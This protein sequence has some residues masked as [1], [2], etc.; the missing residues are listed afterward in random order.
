V[1]EDQSEKWA[2]ALH[3]SIGS[4]RIDMEKAKAYDTPE[5]YKAAKLIVEPQNVSEDYYE[6]MESNIDNWCSFINTNCDGDWGI[7]AQLVKE[8]GY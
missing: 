3:E 2:N 7:I 4:V 5:F 6:F 8:N 1:G